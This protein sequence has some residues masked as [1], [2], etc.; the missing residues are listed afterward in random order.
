MNAL[1]VVDASIA[2]GWF[3]PSQ[4]TPLTDKLLGLA[5]HT[6][7][8]A[9][10]NFPLEVTRVLRRFEREQAMT[11]HA[12]DNA[13]LDLEAL[14]IE[15]DADHP[16]ELARSALVIARRHGL[17]VADAAYLDLA[18]RAGAA[19]ATRDAAL[20]EA[21]RAAGASLIEP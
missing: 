1:I 13:L 6:T 18:G 15:I 3:R 21:A 2:V 16:F 4:A 17:T 19:L 20:R 5:P 10:I 14:G 7:L 8:L 11:R 9:P 12:V